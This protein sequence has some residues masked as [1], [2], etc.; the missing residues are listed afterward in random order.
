[1]PD[2]IES[3]ECKRKGIDHCGTV[4]LIHGV[5]LNE[6]A[7]LSEIKRRGKTAD[8]RSKRFRIVVSSPKF[9]TE[10][11]CLQQRHRFAN[12]I[13]PDETVGRR[14]LPIA[15]V[16]RKEIQFCQREE[17]SLD[18]SLFEIFT[19]DDRDFLQLLWPRQ[20]SLVRTLAIQ[21]VMKI[22]QIG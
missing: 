18:G 2:E 7:F 19:T 20:Q 22:L 4:V 1:M 14:T 15:I 3:I 11:E 8:Q 17:S 13:F 6:T 5:T 21:R 10:L 12:Q 16:H 9:E